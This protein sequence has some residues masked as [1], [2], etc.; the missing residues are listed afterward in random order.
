VANHKPIT[1]R[2]A[3]IIRK[4][5]KLAIEVNAKWSDLFSRPFRYPAKNEYTGSLRVRAYARTYDWLDRRADAAYAKQ[6]HLSL[7]EFEA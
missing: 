6:L 1:T 7:A 3:R 2:K 5:V 4:Q